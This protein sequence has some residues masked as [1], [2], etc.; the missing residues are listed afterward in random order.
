MEEGT[1]CR[2][3]ITPKEPFCEKWHPPEC[4]FYK[5]K[6]GCRFGEKCSYAHR[7]VD[8]QASKRSKNNG[9]KSAVAMLK[10]TRQLGCV[11]QDMEPPK[12]SSILRK[13]SNMQRPIQRVKFTKAIARHTKIL[14]QNPSLGMICPGDLLHQRNPN[15]PEFEDRSQEGTEWQERCAR[16]AA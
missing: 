11:F 7:Q 1:D 15:A 16:E 3:R 10:S 6:S 14:D 12:S 2:A 5:T 8:E 4:L 13:S 9:D